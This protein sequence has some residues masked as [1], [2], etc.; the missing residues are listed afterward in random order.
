MKR[1]V[2]MAILKLCGEAVL[3]TLIAGIVVGIIGY[4][5]KW[6]TSLQY[7][8]AFFIAACLLFI[9]G[10]ASRLGTGREAN[11]S[12][13]L[14]AESFRGMSPSEQANFVL[15]ASNSFRLVILGVL[16]G[17]LLALISWLVTKLF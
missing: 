11:P 12:R 10:T 9:A 16:S 14:Y 7:G 5:S 15:N 6:D 3:F 13:G 4:F 8:N 17:V 2:I 1:L